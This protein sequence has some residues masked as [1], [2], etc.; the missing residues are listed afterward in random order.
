MHTR[1]RTR[2][3]VALAVAAITL[4][5]ASGHAPPRAIGA[6][7]VEAVSR[8]SLVL[9]LAMPLPGLLAERLVEPGDAVAAGQP[10]LRLDDREARSNVAQARLRADSDLEAQAERLNYELA[11][12]REERARQAYEKDAASDLEVREA[13]LE[14]ERSRLAWQLFVQRQQESRM[15][16][17]VAEL[18]L[19]RHTLAAPVAARVEAV[20]VDPGEM[21]EAARPVV[22][23]IV[24]DRLH[25]DAPFHVS[26]TLGLRPG[27]AAWV[28]TEAGEAD[29]VVEGAVVFVSGEA[30]ASTDTR[31][32]RIEFDNPARLP[33][34]TIVR[35]A[36]SPPA[37]R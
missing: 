27:D 28:I 8:P 1:S 9:E 36:L 4:A 10:L 11:L 21:V 26:R 6:D 32:V 18:E 33:A 12:L 34:G 30:D 3:T 24:L 5:V 19:E 37:P 31:I 23:L 22:R 29:A 15:R 20:E 7:T 16:L 35:A 13:S 14:A 2:R 17:D 25:V